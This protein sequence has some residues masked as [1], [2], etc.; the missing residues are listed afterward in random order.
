M[1]PNNNLK[2]TTTCRRPT[3]QH[4]PTELVS[5]LGFGSVLLVETADGGFQDREIGPLV[6]ILDPATLHH[7]DDL[8]V[9]QVVVN[10]RPERCFIRLLLAIL[11]VADDFYLQN[12]KQYNVLK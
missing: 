8:F 5:R 1:S 7:L 3:N 10:R 11:D 12:L 9:A 2:S 4:E 6:R